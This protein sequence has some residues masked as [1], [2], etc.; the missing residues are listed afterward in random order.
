MREMAVATYAPPVSPVAVF[1]KYRNIYE[2]S[3]I[4]VKTFPEE[5]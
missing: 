4:A 5:V 1:L 3:N 2:I